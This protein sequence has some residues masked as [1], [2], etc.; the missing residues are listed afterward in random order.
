[1]SIPRFGSEAGKKST[2]RQLPPKN[3][4][5]QILN[6]QLLEVSGVSKS[7]GGSRALDD[8]DFEVREGEIH[9]LLGEN[10]AG[11]STL[12]KILAGVYRA[13][14]GTVRFRGIDSEVT[15]RT[16]SVSFVHQEL[17]LV[18][19]MTVAENIALVS[20]YPNRN[21]LI[22]WREVGT[23][24]RRVME[25]MDVN[26]EADRAVSSLSMA[27]RSLVAIARG[28]AVHARLFVLDEPTA[29]LPSTDVARLFKVLRR[30]R[31]DGIGVVYVTHRLDEVFQLADRVT[32]L[33]DGQRA[34][35]ARIDEITAADLIALIV[36]RRLS[37]VFPVVPARSA[38]PVLELIDVVT[39]HAGPVSF[40]LHVGEILGLV[41]LRGAG[42]DSVGRVIFGDASLLGG[43]IVVAGAD[44]GI[45]TPLRMIRRG[46]GFVSSKRG[47]EALAES[48]TA[49]EN[50]FLNPAIHRRG[51]TTLLRPRSE[52]HR[53]LDVLRKFDVRPADPAMAVSMFSGGNQQKLVLARWMELGGRLLVLE[54]PTFGVDIGAKAE[55]YAMLMKRL[56]EGGAVIVVSSDFEEVASVCHRALVF[57]RGRVAAELQKDELS[58]AAIT[59]VASSSGPEVG[60]K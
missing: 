3:G 12:I 45:P 10:G 44:A 21:G 6:A 18:D 7:F 36:G 28:L 49:R 40:T 25:M 26:L 30:L 31:A 29:A 38:T 48:L 60:A 15:S 51:G 23:N 24:A 52:L 39:P 8:V 58:Q 50:L 56:A 4:R 27:E 42:H 22:S 46:V 16:M 34:G 5:D 2:A 43:S 20:G 37:E 11:K 41:G 17:G 9:A 1:M 53:A 35:V 32:V 55:I 33:R 47:E 14:A 19:T 13:D 59:R 57:D 54:E